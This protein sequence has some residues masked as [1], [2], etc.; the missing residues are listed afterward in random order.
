[1]EKLKQLKIIREVYSNGQ[2]MIKYLK[3]IGKNEGNTIEDILISY[4]FQSDFYI[5][6]FALTTHLK[7]NY[8][9]YKSAQNIVYD[10]HGN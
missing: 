5:K 8:E 4:D 6:G 1:M 9:T 3:S 2:N 10:V 7:T